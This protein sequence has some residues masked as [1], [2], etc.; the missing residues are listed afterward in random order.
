ME[1]IADVGISILIFVTLA[2]SLNLLVGYTGQLSLAHAVFYGLGGYAVGLLTLPSV[3]TGTIVARGVT[4]GAGWP[5]VPAL[6]VGTVFTFVVALVVALPTL[7]VTGEYVI[8][9]T[10]AFQIVASQLMIALPSVTGGPY[11]L[12]PIP[13]PDLFGLTLTTPMAAFPMFLAVAIGVA[14]LTWWIG[15]SPHGRVLRGIREDEEAV[16]AIGKNTTLAKVLVFG[17]AASL[18][19]LV[20]GMGAAYYRFIAPGNY[21]L[22]VS[23]FLVAIVVLGGSGNVMGV[24]VGGVVLGGLRPLLQNLVGDTAIVWQSVIYGFGLVLIMLLRPE[25][26]FP[27]GVGLDRFLRQR[28]YLPLVSRLG[29]TSGAID[30]PHAGELPREDGQVDVAPDAAVLDR[31]SVVL[32]GVALS[33]RFAG[34]QAVDDVTIELPRGQTTGL[35]GPNGAGKTT[36]FNLLTGTISPDTGHVFLGDEDVTGVPVHHLA[37]RGLVRSFQDVRVFKNLSVLDNVAMAVQHQPGENPLWLVVR[38]LHVMREEAVVLRKA[39]E[40]LSFVGIEHLADDRVGS[41]SFGDSKLVAIARVLATEAEVLLLDEPTSGVD[42]SQVDEIIR[43]I[44]RLRRSGKT[45][46]IIEHSVHL[47]EQLADQVVFLEDGQ[48]IA[49]GP[50]SE[51]RRQERLVEIYFGT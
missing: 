15:V 51:L 30:G 27:E 36:L 20:G 12:T 4:T 43:L 22:T 9:L 10:L 39:R 34:F 6:I 1:Y 18:A 16:A 5:F 3:A 40:S 13:P 48:V 50:M 25:G 26:V 35:V 42:P 14:L 28:L 37:R 11:G 2:L 24:V 44:K 41:L 29:A 17:F 47:I 33:K 8:L 46:C 32:R 23:I 31:P 49:Q 45:I 7:R 19:G 21:S 38:P